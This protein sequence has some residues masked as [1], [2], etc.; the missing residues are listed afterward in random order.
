MAF[1]VNIEGIDGSGKGTQAR[2]LQERLQQAGNTVQLFS[3]PRYAE[4]VFGKAV[5][6]FLNGRFGSL[7]TVDPL[8]VSLLYAGD[9]FESRELLLQAIRDCDFVILD[10]YVASNV[11]HQTCKRTGAQRRELEEWIEQIE[12]GVYRMPKPDLVLLLD[13]PAE[14]A[15][16]LIA[17][18]APRDYT[19][20]AAD[21][22]EADSGYLHNVRDVY[23]QLAADECRW[24]VVDCFRAGQIRP[25]EDIAEQIGR[26]VDRAH[27]AES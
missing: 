23:L 5:G 19:Q 18:K 12:F 26:I 22:Q 10:R 15:R 7:D 14:Q 11:A 24:Q 21:I 25:I 1:L 2:L 4:T 3:F 8:L 13:L 20:S 16:E 6:E 17:R 27:K 9:R